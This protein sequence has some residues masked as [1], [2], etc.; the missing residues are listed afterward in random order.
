[1]F[2]VII[3]ESLLGFFIENIVKLK[4]GL[5]RFATFFFIVTD[6]VPILV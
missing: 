5:W 3:T 6:Y 2:K 1:M 4:F